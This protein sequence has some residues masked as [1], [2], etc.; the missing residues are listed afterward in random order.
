M[1]AEQIEQQ[2]HRTAQAIASN[3]AKAKK[4]GKI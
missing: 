1:T 2:K 4:D 3:L